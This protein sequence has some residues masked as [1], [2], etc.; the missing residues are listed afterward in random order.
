M[1]SLTHNFTHTKSL[2]V[3]TYLDNIAHYVNVD[4]TTVQGLERANRLTMVESGLADF[5]ATPYLG[6]AASLFASKMK[7]G[8]IFAI[9][10]DPV[11]RT[12]ARYDYLRGLDDTYLNIPQ[13]LVQYAESDLL[14]E[15][16]MTKVLANLTME[17]VV[18]LE[19]VS[20]AKMM[21]EHY[22]VVGVANHM[23]Q[24][25]EY[26]YDYFGWEMDVRDWKSCQ[27]SFI[28]KH[29]FGFVINP[30]S[31]EFSTLADRNWADVEVYDY[32]KNRFEKHAKRF[33]VSSL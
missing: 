26:F 9:L 16:V 6:Q 8:R 30:E 24:S 20:I 19:H 31:D 33:R 21:I 23:E 3:L 32:A 11:V 10:E 5:M 17:T 18:T 14:E 28:D 27:T 7:T 29:K 22:V 2:S 13:T 25:L 4:T 1:H 12:M 15:N